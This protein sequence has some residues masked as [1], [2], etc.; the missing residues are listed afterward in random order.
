MG[1]VVNVASRL[2]GLNKFVG[3]RVCM[4]EDTRAASFDASTRPIGRFQL[5]GK[6]RDI[7]IHQLLPPEAADT[8]YT[9][10]YR[11]AYT[12]LDQGAPSALESFEALLRENPD[13]GSVRFHLERLRAG[14]CSAIVVME[15][16]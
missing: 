5:K 7:L 13:D 11:E 2:E 14:I 16:K 3:S 1:D 4:S 6:T 9:S 8:A 12:L 15:E 10:R